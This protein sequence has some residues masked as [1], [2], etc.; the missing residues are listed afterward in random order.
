MPAL[1]CSAD[2]PDADDLAGRL[3]GM[4]EPDG[5]TMVYRAAGTDVLDCVQPNRSFTIDVAGE[6]FLVRPPDG[7]PVAERDGDR[8]VI[9]RSL[10]DDAMIGAEWIEVDL[11]DLDDDHDDALRR[12]LGPDLAGYLLAAEPPTSGLQQASSLVPLA[13][14]LLPVDPPGATPTFRLLL[15]ADAYA[16]ASGLDASEAVVPP[17]VDIS[18]TDDRVSRVVVRPAGDQAAGG[19]IID[20]PDPP[21]A[22]PDRPLP[23]PTIDLDQL[24]ATDL[25]AA[26]IPGCAV[27]D[28][29]P[30]SD[31]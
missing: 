21:T 25:R 3:A 28:E 15:D 9:H 24:A 30:A 11:G 31:P 12:V 29:T 4:D 27:G 5:F 22:L 1:G 6:R 18:I 23:G 10:L 20:F 7:T 2:E 16:E 19:W 26:P 14:S 8:L 17:L 13:T